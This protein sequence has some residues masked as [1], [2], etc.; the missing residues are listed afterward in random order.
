[1]KLILVLLIVVVASCL[2]KQEGTKPLST[3]S[4]IPRT[5]FVVKG[6][7]VDYWCEVDVHDH[8]NNAFIKIYDGVTGKLSSLFNNRLA[9]SR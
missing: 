8:K 3:I 6:K 9:N 4:N 7:N 5:A 2:R 1:M